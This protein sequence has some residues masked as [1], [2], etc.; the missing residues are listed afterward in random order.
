[1]TN[2]NRESMTIPNKKVLIAEDQKLLNKLL[3]IE[4]SEFGFEVDSVFDGKAALKKLKETDYFC[5]IT[6]LFMPEMDGIELVKVLREFNQTLPIVVVSA[7]NMSNVKKALEHFV[8]I[9]FIDKPLTDVKLRL[10]Q[11]YLEQYK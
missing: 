11:H 10:L 7:S 1:M 4:V 5:L 2:I 9:N 6:D 8:P 3:T